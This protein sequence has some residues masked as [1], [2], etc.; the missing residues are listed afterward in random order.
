MA[1]S[2]SNLDCHNFC[3]ILLE[4]LN[5]GVYFVD[6]NKKI[7][8]WNSRAEQITGY[9]A[10]DVIGK[11]CG[12]D[13]LIHINE[14]GK[15]C[16]ENPEFCPVLKTLNS[17][18]PY[19]TE[20]YFKH[21]EGYRVLVQIKTYPVFDENHN[22]IGAIEIFY[23]NSEIDDLN[24]RI[25]ELEKL[26][27]IDSLTKIANRRYIEIQL[28]ARLNEFRRFGWQFG[29]LFIDID[30]FKSI[31]DKYGHETGDRVLKMLANLLVKNSRSFDLVGRWGG[32]EFIV[33]IPNVNDTQLYTIAHKFKNLVS[34]SNIRVNSDFINITVS[35]GATL[36]KEKDT[37]KSMIKR[38]DKLM[39]QSKQN[40]RNRV[41]TDFEIS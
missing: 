9:K 36:I 22:V 40:G 2:I 12:D 20:L 3:Q 6:R 30:L 24:V 13:I 34:L 33:I 19:N 21:R 10:E 31:N 32:E 28:H 26:A 14:E 37:L 41:T 39:Y 17:K 29:L 8:Y 4:N 23:D 25:H 27:L 16:C 11:S 15:K 1:Q 35:I 5:Q 18:H 38:A 7:I